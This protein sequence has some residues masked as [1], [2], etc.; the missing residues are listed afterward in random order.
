MMY[1]FKTTSVRATLHAAWHQ[2]TAHSF[3]S[4]LCWQKTDPDNRHEHQTVPT[5]VNR[6]YSIGEP[7]S[8]SLPWAIAFEID[9]AG[10]AILSA[11][12][13]C[14]HT[15]YAST[16]RVVQTEATP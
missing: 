11:A 2:T 5:Q 9:I 16:L 8:Q 1:L 14:W 3:T 7:A 15:M 10:F 13:G 12:R 6:H 4:C